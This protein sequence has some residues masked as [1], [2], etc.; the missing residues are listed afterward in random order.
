MTRVS[1]TFTTPEQPSNSSSTVRVKVVYIDTDDQIQTLTYPSIT[2]L[3]GV[4]GLIAGQEQSFTLLIPKLKSL[5]GITL[6]P[7]TEDMVIGTVIPIG[8]ESQ[9]DPS[10]STSVN[11][12]ITQRPAAADD[13]IV[14]HIAF[15]SLG[16]SYDAYIDMDES[17]A[18]VTVDST[19]VKRPRLVVRV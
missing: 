17:E 16:N 3:M 7:T 2:D 12:V 8:V 14:Y 4:N 9:L 11:L 5:S 15:P 6:T 10:I 19:Y 18:S 1:F 13:A